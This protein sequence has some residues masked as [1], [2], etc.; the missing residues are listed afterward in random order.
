MAPIERF[1]VGDVAGTAVAVCVRNFLPFGGLLL[2]ASAPMLLWRAVADIGQLGILVNGE[3]LIGGLLT[4]LGMYWLLA[5]VTYGVIRDLRGGRA[6][7][8]ELA[9]QA[10]RTAPHVAGATLLAGLVTVVGFLC[11]IVPGVVL[12]LMFSMVL[13]VAVVERRIGSAL[14]RSHR[15]TNGYKWRILGLAL[16]YVVPLFL[17]VIANTVTTATTAMLFLQFLS[18]GIWAT[19]MAVAYHRLRSLEEGPDSAIARVFD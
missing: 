16:L 18:Q 19:W 17:M 14:A 1:Q 10:F 9:T 6:D 15:L 3:D 4:I 5:G 12:T 8:L 7:I 11:L 13:P 2:L